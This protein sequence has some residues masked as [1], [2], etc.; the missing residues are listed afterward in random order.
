M[1]IILTS[2]SFNSDILSSYYFTISHIILEFSQVFNALTHSL[3]Q[4]K[5]AEKYIN[6]THIPQM[7]SG[8]S[9]QALGKV[10][11][12]FILAWLMWK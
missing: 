5:N 12:G 6:R 7:T 2:R 3:N 1:L 9:Q 4:L 10:F 8:A 11:S